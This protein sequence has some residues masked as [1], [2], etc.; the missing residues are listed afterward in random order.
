VVFYVI[1]VTFLM[2]LFINNLTSAIIHFW[3]ILH[4]NSFVMKYCHG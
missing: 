4:P 2:T 1:V 3:Y